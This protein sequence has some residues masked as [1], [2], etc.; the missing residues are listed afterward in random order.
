MNRR[1]AARRVWLGAL[2]IPLVLAA[3]GSPGPPA[4]ADGYGDGPVPP[5]RDGFAIGVAVG[6]SLFLGA[7]ELNAKKGVGGALNIRVGTVATQD[8]LWLLELQAGSYLVDLTNESGAARIDNS[9]VMLTL[10]GQLYVRESVWLRAGAG[11]AGFWEEEQGMRRE[12]TGRDGLAFAAGGGYDFFRR[13]R[14]AVD[15][16]L[17]ASGALLDG[18]F[19][20]HGALLLGVI[21]Y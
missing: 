11:V 20:G 21:W 2:A 15:L 19:L 9:Y 16:E 7:G 17:L 5:R 3:V 4:F 14:F 8:L 10:G 18:D 1:S 13:G 12:G 6:P